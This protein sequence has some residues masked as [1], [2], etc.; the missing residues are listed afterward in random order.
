MESKRV[1]IFIQSTYIHVC[2]I[3]YTSL[4]DGWDSSAE[5]KT[6][7]YFY[8]I[9]YSLYKTSSKNEFMVS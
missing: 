2:C 9:I 4:I 5:K 6:F 3:M 1:Y 7:L 8:Q